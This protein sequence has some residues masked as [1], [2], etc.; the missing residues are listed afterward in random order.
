[1]PTKEGFIEEPA[2]R[3][4]VRYETDVLVIGGGA[5][6]IMAAVAAARLGSKVLLVER[7][8][9]LGGTLTMVTLGSVCGLY[10]VTQEHIYP[11]VQGLSE[12]LFRRMH[13]AGGLGQPSRWL[14]TASL[15]YD[16]ATFKL[17]ADEFVCEAGV[18]LAFHSIAVGAL[19]SGSRVEG[20]IFESRDG[21][22][23]CRAKTVVDCSGDGD[24]S[25]FSAA[26]FDLDLTTLQAPT[27]MFHM[28]GVDVE[29][30]A[31]ISRPQM[32][33]YLEAAVAHGIDLPRTAGGAFSTRPNSMHLNITKVS[34]DGRI[35]NP[36]DT[37]D[38][39]RAEIEGRRQ[40]LRYQE[41]FRRF[42]PGYEHCYIEDMGAHIGVRE[43]RRIRGDY[44]LSQHDVLNEARFDDVVACGAWPVEKHGRDRSTEW[45]FLEP[46]TYYQ[47]PYRMLL[48]HGV[49]GLLVAGRC[50]S[51][52]H[53]AHASMRVAGIC[54]ALGEAAGTAAA[55][56][57]QSD[58]TPRALDTHLLQSQLERQGAWLGRDGMPAPV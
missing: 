28:G 56:A 31:Q 26:G 47:M 13:T 17:V 40:L 9:Y 19:R 38:L 24:V 37:E 41:A 10:S 32:H 3:T 34:V 5:A 22:W 49:E 27:T 18:S 14:K 20:V 36:L 6:G 29:R 50:A 33:E 57:I 2:R 52:Q 25:A 12:D 11:V 35:P 7:N 4:R 46:G 54:M 39:T 44:Q 30:A 55:L 42:V 23:A 51:A 16:P 15:P 43:S 8:G 21:R 53:D 1:M 58:C 45:G 48:P